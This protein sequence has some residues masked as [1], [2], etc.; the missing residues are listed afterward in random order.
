MQYRSVSDLNQTIIRNLHKLPREL[1]LVVGIPRS[2]LLAANLLS[3]AAN[4]PMTDL[5]SFI[6]GKTYS[7]GVTKRRAVL[8]QDM[9]EARRVLIIDDSINGGNAMAEARAKVAHL[10][11]SDHYL[12]AAVYGSY[13][14]HAEADLIFEVVPQPRLFQWNFMHHKFLE[15]SCVDIDGVLCVDPTHEENDDGIAYQ[16]FLAEAIP[17]HGPTRKI[18]YLVTSR[19]EK[20]RSLTEAWLARHRIQYGQLVM[21]D[22]PSKAER[23][24]LGVHGSFKADFY[25]SSPATLFIESEDEQAKRIAALSGKPVL[26]T[27]THQ[28]YQS[29]S[30]FLNSPIRHVRS[31]ER[32]KEMLKAAAKAMLGERGY[33][34]LKSR[35]VRST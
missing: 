17:L 10:P 25:K 33:R 4:I 32:P 23:Q 29:S 22:L 35:V 16:T 3:L 21:L 8:D 30:N 1:D 15:E 34:A 12:F 13:P 31:D 19:L 24:R 28:L 26:C 6:S 7:S 5:D 14:Q 20:Y 18:G 27:E 11:N 9:A 2:G